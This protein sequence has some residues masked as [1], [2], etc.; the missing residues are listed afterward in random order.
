MLAELRHRDAAQRQR[1]RVLAQ[2]DALERAE[3]IAGG[4]GARGGG[5]QGVH[6]RQVT[7]ATASVAETAKAGTTA[8]PLDAQRRARRESG[9]SACRI[10]ERRRRNA[11][12]RPAG[13]V[14]GVVRRQTESPRPRI[15]ARRR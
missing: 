9:L 15:R 4:E 7:R 8:R 10:L 3:R 12:A 11:K 5:D 1:R 6:R 2:R 13:T 14:S